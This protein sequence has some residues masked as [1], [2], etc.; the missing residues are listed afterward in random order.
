MNANFAPVMV[1]SGEPQTTRSVSAGVEVRKRQRGISPAD[2]VKGDVGENVG[3][4]HLDDVQGGTDLLLGLASGDLQFPDVLVRDRIRGLVERRPRTTCYALGDD[5]VEI[6][7]SIR[8]L[9]RDADQVSV[10]AVAE[11][12]L[13]GPD[14]DE[15]R[16]RRIGEFRQGDGQFG[17]LD[18]KG[19]L[20]GDIEVRIKDTVA[21]LPE[22]MA[23]VL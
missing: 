18:K 5:G 22:L 19:H 11:Q 10:A 12:L 23:Y 7:C 8:V 16:L 20:R 3:P 9:R 4:D 14:T 15:V 13:R 21:A 6:P 1:A 2:K 17:S